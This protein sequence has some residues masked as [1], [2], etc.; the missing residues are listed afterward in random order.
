MPK[1]GK[2]TGCPKLELWPTIA[3]GAWFGCGRGLSA[4]LCRTSL[5]SGRLEATFEEGDNLAGSDRLARGPVAIFLRALLSSAR[6]E[7]APGGGAEGGGRSSKILPNMA[8]AAGESIRSGGPSCGLAGGL[9]FI[10]S[11]D[12]VPFPSSRLDSQALS[13]PPSYPPKV[14]QV[15]YPKPFS[16]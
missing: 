10:V 2:G 15:E 7:T 11:R 5:G 9:P 6:G 16:P 12:Y 8:I 14:L 13:G 4:K 1:P 3:L